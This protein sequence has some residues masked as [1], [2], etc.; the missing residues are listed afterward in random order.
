VKFLSIENLERELRVRKIRDGTVIDHI[1]DGMA[2]KVLKILGICGEEENVVSIVMHVPS[3]KLGKKDIVKVEGRELD[4]KEAD[5][6][7]LIAPNATINIV[8]QYRIAR[9]ERVK[10]PDTIKG[11]PKC[12]NP[13]CITNSSEPVEPSFTVEE[14]EPVILR[15]N[16]CSKTMTIEDILR[17]L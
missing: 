6:I 8:R 10:L 4:P 2:L 17:N 7:A 14:R 3:E 15:C 1:S 11:F 16:Y 9:K 5:K 13:N 12:V